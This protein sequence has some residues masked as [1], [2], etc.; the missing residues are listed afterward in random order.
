MV[1]KR[2]NEFRDRYKCM[3][4]RLK[5]II[6]SL[7]KQDMNFHIKIN[8]KYKKKNNGTG[9]YHTVPVYYCLGQEKVRIILIRSRKQRKNNACHSTPLYIIQYICFFS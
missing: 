2:Q 3:A 7:K 5:K 1:V 8:I 4:T 6:I 9:I